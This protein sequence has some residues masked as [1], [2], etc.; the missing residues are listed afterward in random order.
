MHR[1]HATTTWQGSTAVGYEHFGRDHSGAAPP[2]EPVLQL[3]GDA[4]F[5]GDPGRLNPEQLVVLAASSCQ[6]LSFLAIA[7]RARIDVVDYHDEATG[8]MPAEARP[9]HITSIVL[10]PRITVRGTV[11]PARVERLVALAH[12][13]CYVANSLITEIRVVPVIDVLPPA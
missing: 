7:A 11:D 8:E 13:E 12:D 10:Q 6:L 1:Y 4:A 5:R 3:S 2:A 9:A